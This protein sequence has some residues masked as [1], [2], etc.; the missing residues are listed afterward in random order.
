MFRAIVNFVRKWKK[1]DD[2]A[3]KLRSLDSHLLA[4]IGVERR[5]IGAFVRGKL[6]QR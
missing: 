4:D 6:Q 2:D 1:L 5:R 3:L